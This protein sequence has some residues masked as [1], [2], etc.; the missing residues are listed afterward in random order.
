MK[1]SS[2][3]EMDTYFNTVQNLIGKV[4]IV[5]PI[6]FCFSQHLPRKSYSEA[7]EKP[8]KKVPLIHSGPWSSCA[9][10]EDRSTGAV[11]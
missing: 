8:R 5:H 7:L 4:S 10:W 1:T 9:A 3:G 2:V 6:L 11:G